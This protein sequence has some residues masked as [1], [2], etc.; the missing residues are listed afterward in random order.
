MA[1]ENVEGRHCAGLSAGLLTI[2]RLVF[3]QPFLLPGLVLLIEVEALV[4]G[5]LRALALV[6]RQP[7]LG[8]GTV[9]RCGKVVNILGCATPDH[10]ELRIHDAE[11]C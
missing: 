5:D 3:R 1:C 4:L 11:R 9:G 2:S 10:F 6:G 7:G 8:E